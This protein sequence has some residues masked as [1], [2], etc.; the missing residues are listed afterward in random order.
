MSDDL[1]L[2]RRE[3][4][5]FS[6]ILLTLYFSTWQFKDHFQ[7]ITLFGFLLG[8]NRSYYHIKK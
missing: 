3:D 1:N 2:R 7:P 8:R 6:I 4:T 5:D